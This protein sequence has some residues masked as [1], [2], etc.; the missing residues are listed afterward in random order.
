MNAVG[1]HGFV[2]ARAKNIPISGSII[3]TIL[4]CT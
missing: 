1:K 2:V 4:N 3:K